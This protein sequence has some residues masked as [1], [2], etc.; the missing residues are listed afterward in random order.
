[1]TVDPYLPGHGDA[2]YTVRHY[3]LDLDY[4]L[5]NNSLKGQAV[6]T[7]EALEDLSELTLDLH[8]LKVVKLSGPRISKHSHTDGRL[9]IRLQQPISVGKT[10]KLTVTYR[11]VPTPVPDKIGEAGWE[12]LADGVIV[13]SQ[14]G[15]APSWFPCNDRPD[16]K[17]PYRIT[18]STA[19][20]YFVVANGQRTAVRRRAG[21][22]TWT[23]EQSEPMAPYLATVQIGRYAEHTIP[24][25]VPLTA[26]VPPARRAAF[27]RAFA[28]QPQMIELFERLFGPYPFGS[29][30]VV[31]TDDS[32]EIPLEAQ[33]L[34]IFG[35]NLLSRTWDAQRLIAHEL[36][37]QWFGNAVTLR[38]MRDIWLHEGF[39]CYAEW[40]W[41][42]ESGGPSTHE[43]AEEAWERLRRHRGS[44]L[45]GDPGVSDVFDDRVYKRGALT[46]HAI[47]LTIGDEAFFELLQ[48]WVRR[49]SGGNVSTDD[50]TA[51][52]DELGHSEVADVVDAW[53]Y[54]IALPP[55]P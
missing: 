16:A 24:A 55:L 51:L 45:L 22:T 48:T 47:R 20:D 32:L 11:G 2:S 40:L 25:S 35:S 28:D 50:F 41:S 54:Q 49:H 52:A 46:L 31:V 19:S 53:V 33:G 12:E 39:A 43:R 15:G 26:A 17:A 4:A 18:I 10:T 34:S 29:Y 1:M 42:Q 13:A 5:E 23:Y 36:S 44:L 7:I 6:L 14:P 37:H 21:R 8:A 9:R 38:R 3:D 30:R 27:D